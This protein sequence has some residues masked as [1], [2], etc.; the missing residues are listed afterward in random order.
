MRIAERLYLRRSTE[1]RESGVRNSIMEWQCRPRCSDGYRGAH[2]LSNRGKGY[3]ARNELEEHQSIQKSTNGDCR[4]P[5]TWGRIR[6]AE[7]DIGATIQSVVRRWESG[8]SQP[9]LDSAKWGGIECGMKSRS[10]NPA[11]G[12]QGM[13]F[14]REECWKRRNWLWNEIEERQSRLGSA[15]GDWGATMLAEFCH[16]GYQAAQRCAI[17][18]CSGYQSTIDHWGWAK[19]TSI[20]ILRKH[21]CG[22]LSTAILRQ[23][24]MTSCRCQR[25]RLQSEMLEMLECCNLVPQAIGGEEKLMVN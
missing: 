20:F 5:K 19:C 7:W 15:D 24:T 8:S 22:L 2:L 10:T 16:R 17:D 6:S 18:E 3:R 14:L 23:C 4:A 11:R 1:K 13:T 21:N 9:K 25:K 12:D